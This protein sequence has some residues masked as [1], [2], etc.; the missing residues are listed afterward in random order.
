M[1]DDGLR[2]ILILIVIIVILGCIYLF[3]RLS[4]NKYILK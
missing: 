4:G 1:K 2:T 3:M